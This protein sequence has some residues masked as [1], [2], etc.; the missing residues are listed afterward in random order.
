VNPASAMREAAT[1]PEPSG[2][3]DLA[4]RMDFVRHVH[5]NVAENIHLADTKAG[6]IAAGS[7][8]LLNVLAA[9]ARED[10]VSAAATFEAQPVATAVRVLVLIVAVGSSAT[11]LL[12]AYFALRPRIHGPRTYIAFP[13]LAH[14]SADQY[15]ERVEAQSDAGLVRELANDTIALSVIALTKHQMVT[16]AIKP[17]I[18]AA[19]GVAVLLLLG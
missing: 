9:R 12:F 18:A 4:R 17:L 1:E 7:A 19:L 3:V 10:L 14:M 2:S 13:E 5:S 16:R 15:L 6:L 11:A 8:A